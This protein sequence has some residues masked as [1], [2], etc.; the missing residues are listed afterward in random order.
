MFYFFYDFTLEIALADSFA[1]NFLFCLIGI[2]L[3]YIVRYS[4]PDKTNFWNVIFNHFTYLALMLVVWIGLP[5][6]LLNYLFGAFK[7]YHD[8]LLISIPYR[9]FSGIL[10][11]TTIGMIYYLLIYYRNLQEKVQTESRLREV[12]KETE[13]NMLKSQINPHFLF[14]SLN[15]ISSLTITNPEKARDMVIKLSDF[16]RYSVSTNSKR[17]ATLENELTNIQ[18]YLEIEKVRFGDKLQFSF[19]IEGTCK[20]HKIPL[21]LLQ[22]LVENAIKHGVYESTEQVTIE[23]KCKFSGGF[24]EITVENDFDPNAHPRK[25]TGLGLNNIRERLRL[26]YKTDKLLKTSV[27]G[28]KFFVFLSLPNLESTEPKA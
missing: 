18:R 24:L 10:Y 2:S 21:M 7:P 15:S 19:N 28:T 11:Y 5:F 16:L 23:M 6:T 17:F 25:G 1:F 9:L 3:W 26:L 14:N 8:F 13:L 4:I 20:D 22:P 12:L 27:V